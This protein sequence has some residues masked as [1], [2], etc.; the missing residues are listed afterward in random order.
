MSQYRNDDLSYQ[1]QLRRTISSLTNK[2]LETEIECWWFIS[3]HYND[4]HTNEDNLINDVKELKKKLRRVIY[5]KR[6]KTV[7]GLGSYAYPRMLFFHE[8]SHKGTGQFH[9]HLIIEKL[10][11][12]LNTYT[13]VYDLFKRNLP[14]QVSAISKWKSI[15]I[16]RM[17][18]ENPDYGISQYL[19]KQTVPSRITLDAFNS[20]LQSVR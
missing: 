1:K 5:R 12:D 2:I 15:D 18:P 17:C 6:D 3:F 19:T 13:S 20:D 4:N 8:V 9:T 7:K 16:Q 10:P 14:R 11:S